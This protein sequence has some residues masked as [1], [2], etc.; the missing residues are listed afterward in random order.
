MIADDEDAIRLLIKD[1]LERSGEDYEII[2]ASN[3]QRVLELLPEAR[4]DLLLLDIVMPEL[5]G[6]AVCDRVRHDPALRHTKVILVSGKG[7]DDIVMAGL[8]AGASDFVSKPFSPLDLL[9]R[10]RKVLGD[11]VAVG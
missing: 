1:V 9:A 11:G 6:I 4:P 8:S 3:G 7:A 10:V 2:E 5:G